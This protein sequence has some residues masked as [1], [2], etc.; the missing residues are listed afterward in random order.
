MDLLQNINPNVVC[1]TN[2]IIDW[3]EDEPVNLN[4]LE[5]D[6]RLDSDS[7]EDDDNITNMSNIEDKLISTDQA[8][9]SVNRIIQ[10][11]EEN[12]DAVEYSRLLVLHNNK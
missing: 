3:N 4:H 10:W 8:L 6:I 12:G 5:N 9:R 7:E 1:E 2:D 11:S